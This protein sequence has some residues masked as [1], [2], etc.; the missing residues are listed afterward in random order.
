MSGEELSLQS[1][2]NELQE[3]KTK[4]ENR[5]VFQELANQFTDRIEIETSIESTVGNMVNEE[6]EFILN[7]KIDINTSGNKPSNISEY[8][9]DYLTDNF[10]INL[11]YWSNCV[12]KKDNSG[13]KITSIE[14]TPST[15]IHDYQLNFHTHGDTK[16]HVFGISKLSISII[17]FPIVVKYSLIAAEIINREQPLAEVEFKC[18]NIVLMMGGLRKRVE[19][20]NEL[21]HPG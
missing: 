18:D 21:I 13:E 14:I 8:S 20:D 10:S 7:V 12:Q 19:I 15:L 17:N 6:E 11:G 5:N 9:F 3:L 1:L 4:Y 2:N 16:H